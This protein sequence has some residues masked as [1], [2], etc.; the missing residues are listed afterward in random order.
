M[1]RIIKRL[2]CTMP[3]KKS[4]LTESCKAADKALFF[5]V[6]FLL[7]QQKHVVGLIMFVFRHINPCGSF[8]VVSQRKGEKK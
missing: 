1:N 2:K 7:S 3:D 6:S 8:C 5:N 4:I